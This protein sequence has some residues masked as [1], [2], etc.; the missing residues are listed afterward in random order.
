MSPKRRNCL[1][2]GCLTV[3]VLGVLAVVALFITFKVVTNR[4]LKQY[5]DTAPAE[6]PPLQVTADDIA[7]TQQRW[8]DFFADLAKGGEIRPMALTAREVNALLARHAAQLT[9][10][11]RVMIEGDHLRAQVSVPLDQTRMSVLQG[12]YLNGDITLKL[13]V[14]GGLLQVRPEQLLVRGQPLPGFLMQH[15]RRQNWADN[16]MNNP[17]LLAIVQELETVTVTN[18]TLVIVPKPP[19]P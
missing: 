15:L 14:E 17:D 19:P 16:A 1:L 7:A 10:F 4:A 12:R 3:V 13:A 9:N 18:G 5:T 11:V 8:D 6:L 2:A